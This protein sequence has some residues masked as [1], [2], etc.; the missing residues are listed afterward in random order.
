MLAPELIVLGPS[1][2]LFEVAEPRIN[3]APLVLEIVFDPTDWRKKTTSWL[4]EAFVARPS[5]V[6]A[7]SVLETFAV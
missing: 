3:T 5:M 6:I 2:A 1:N 4:N 7:P